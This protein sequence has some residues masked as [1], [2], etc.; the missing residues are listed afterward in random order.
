MLHR[1][2]PQSLAKAAL[3]LAAL[4]TPLALQAQNTPESG[5]LRLN[6]LGGGKTADALAPKAGGLTERFEIQTTEDNRDFV[7]KVFRLRNAIATEVYRNILLAVQREEGFVDRIVLPERD[8]VQ[9]SLLVVTAPDWMIPYLEESIAALDVTGLEDAAWGTSTAFV[10]P[11][12]RRPSELADLIA[13][14]VASGVQILAAD[15]SRNVLYLEDTPSWW[16][17]VMAGLEAF[18]QPADMVEAH[19]KIYEIKESDLEDVG[20]DW[21]VWKRYASAGGIDFSWDNS[22][23][24]GSYDLALQSF[25]ASLS[26]YPGLATEFLNYLANTGNANIL[27]DTTVN[28]INGQTGSVTDVTTIPYLM[29]NEIGVLTDS[30]EFGEGVTVDITPTIGS[31]TIEFVVGASVASHVG[32]TPSQQVPILAASTVNTVLTLEPGNVGLIGGLSR[33]SKVTNRTGLPVLKDIPYIWPLFAR[34]VDRESRSQIIVSITPR[35][36]AVDAAM[37]VPAGFVAPAEPAL[38]MDE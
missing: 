34:Q 29:F 11:Q 33:V 1:C 30:L 20:L 8:G 26:F 31:E 3:L 22:G 15:D 32:Y 37:M 28:I 7:V 2:S 6:Q 5:G 17:A 36:T 13:A 35:R 12:H 23:N 24:T 25:S 19:V 4:A 38:D 16:G 14:S 10:R 18:D 27:T 9:E 21:Y